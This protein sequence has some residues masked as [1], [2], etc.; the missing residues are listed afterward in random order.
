MPYWHRSAYAQF[1][2]GVAQI[3]LETGRYE[4]LP[5]EQ[6]SVKNE[7]YI[8]IQCPKYSNL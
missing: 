2:C 3:R 8:L 1:R 5:E 6:K 7:E 4:R